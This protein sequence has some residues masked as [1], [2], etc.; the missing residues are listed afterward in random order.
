MDGFQNIGDRLELFCDDYL[1]D[2]IRTTAD[3]RLHTPVRRETVMVNDEPWEG[4]VS[5]YFN[6]FFD[7]DIGKYRMYYKAGQAYHDTPRIR[8][9]PSSQFCYAESADGIRWE[10]P[11]LGLWGDTNILTRDLNIDNFFVIRDLNP[12]CPP[13]ERYKAVCGCG[14]LW[15]Y[16]SAD[17]VHFDLDHGVE[18]MDRGAG[19]FDS[20][21]TVYWDE[22]QGRYV[23]FSRRSSYMDGTVPENREDWSGFA[24]CIRGIVYCTSEDFRTWSEPVPL[25]YSDGR[26]FEMYTNCVSR[27]KRAPHLYVGFPTRYVQRRKWDENYDALGGREARRRLYEMTGEGRLGL[28]VT[29]V[30]FM[31]SRD[32]V[33]WTR[34]PEAFLRPGPQN[35]ENWLYGAGYPAVGLLET[36]PSVPGSAPELSLLIPDGRLSAAP[37]ELV[38]YSIRTDGFVSMHAPYE[39]KTVTTKPFIYNGENLA[40]NF[41]TSAAG[42]IRVRLRDFHANELISPE[43][44]GDTVSRQV[45]FLNGSAAEMRGIPVVMEICLS[46]ADVYSFRFR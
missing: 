28:A 38:R 16:P 35:E 13:E 9:H 24:E 34:F 2:T 1:I 15:Y 26:I 37:N 5:N 11:N 6:F 42:H 27:Y 32:G 41:S 39:E 17:G 3:R 30:L 23:S 7:E 31:S 12:A 14:K 33:H 20:L 45:P 25:E 21:N 22:T 46:D 18:I 43:L 8:I 10:K 29:E 19:N 40:L 4:N 36:A 44:F